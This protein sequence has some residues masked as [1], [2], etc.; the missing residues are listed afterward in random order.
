MAWF[1]IFFTQT[2]SILFGNS[3]YN[4]AQLDKTVNTRLVLVKSGKKT[5]VVVL[6]YPRVKVDK[7][8]DWTITVAAI[9][10]KWGS[11]Q[12]I[13]FKTNNGLIEWDS[14]TYLRFLRPEEHFLGVK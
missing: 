10:D 8:S 13:S 14:N 12:P 5:E 1:D 7:G 6:S 9:N 4:L 2:V 3:P 11:Q